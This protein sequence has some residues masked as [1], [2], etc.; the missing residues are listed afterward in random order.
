MTKS[1]SL[2]DCVGS[3]ILPC[4]SLHSPEG[5]FSPC[6]FP[7]ERLDCSSGWQDAVLG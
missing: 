4:S 6:G 5:G 3:L 7:V 1:T 2:A